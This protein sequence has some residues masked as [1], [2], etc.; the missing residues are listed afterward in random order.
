MQ[1]RIS[2]YEFSRVMYGQKPEY[3]GWMTLTVPDFDIAT[4]PISY[5]ISFDEECRL[6]IQIFTEDRLLANRP[7]M[8]KETN[9][10]RILTEKQQTA[11]IEFFMDVF[12]KLFMPRLDAVEDGFGKV[13]SR[14]S[15][16]YGTDCKISYIEFIGALKFA[17]QVQGGVRE[18]NP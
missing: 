9:F 11:L 12:Y 8:P 17:N 3:K 16:L 15:L 2:S 6:S 14:V 7:E 18:N 5:V 10:K 1:L 4:K 13:Y